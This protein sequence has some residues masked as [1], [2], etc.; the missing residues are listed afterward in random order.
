MVA[1]AVTPMGASGKSLTGSLDGVLHLHDNV[2]KEETKPHWLI[3]SGVFNGTIIVLVFLNAIQIGIEADYPHLPVWAD[4]EH[5]FTAAFLTEAIVKISV[6]GKTYFR[7]TF[8]CVDFFLMM[9]G[10]LDSWVLSMIYYTGEE[11]ELQSL[12]M[13]RLIRIFRIARVVKVAR[14]NKDIMLVFSGIV[15]AMRSACCVSFVLVATIYVAAIF[16]V[17]TMSGESM[18][19]FP[20]YTQDMETINQT[21]M[22]QE[23]NPYVRF[24]TMRN[25]MM[26]LFNLAIQAEF[27]EILWPLLL[28]QPIFVPFLLVFTITVTYGMMNLI[29][30]LVVE[31]VIGNARAF[32]QESAEQKAQVKKRALNN[33]TKTMHQIVSA[34]GHLTADVISEADGN[35]MDMMRKLIHAM[36]LPGY[37]TPFHLLELLDENGNGKIDE[38]ELIEGTARLVDALDM[39]C[40][41]QHMCILQR[42]MHCLKAEVFQQ[43]KSMEQAIQRGFQDLTAKLCG[44]T[45]GSE[46]KPLQEV[47]DV[48]QRVEFQNF[49]DKVI[50]THEVGLKQAR[51]QLQAATFFVEAQVA[52][53]HNE[54]ILCTSTSTSPE[55]VLRSPPL[56]MRHVMTQSQTPWSERPSDR[57]T[58]SASYQAQIVKSNGQTN[59]QTHTAQELLSHSVSKALEGESGCCRVMAEQELDA[60]EET[61]FSDQMT[62]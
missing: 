9:M 24:G 51:D 5:F 61:V 56:F 30:G 40:P 19:N 45:S 42:S 54:S 38:D 4:L 26:T 29:I 50:H 34:T 32:D 7:R 36:G 33:I 8:N 28:H 57:F 27:S 17:N 46:A 62:L 58:C 13:L 6:L 25:A 14:Q 18:K 60:L 16:C 43:Q 41:F 49:T 48:A 21:D 20:G 53:A 15:E 11:S 44:T 2:D 10:V 55:A 22:M 31:S 37:F 39:N 52:A 12:T 1:K 3:D 47:H 23:F 35:D 59:G